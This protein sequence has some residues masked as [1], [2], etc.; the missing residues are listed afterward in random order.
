MSQKRPKFRIMDLI[1]ATLILAVIMAAVVRLSTG[2]FAGVSLGIV[3]AAITISRMRGYW[4]RLFTWS[5]CI[6]PITAIICLYTAWLAAWIHVGH[7]PRNTFDDPK[8]LGLWVEI[9][10]KLTYLHLLNHKEALKY[11]SILVLL[12]ICY[13]FIDRKSRG[14]ELAIL[15]FAPAVLWLMFFLLLGWD[16]G[17][18]LEWYMD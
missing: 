9:P 17:G 16:P 14:I 10:Y 15:L 13:W 2:R 7:R 18:V 8:Y 4:I 1:E 3:L 5:S 11:C 12:N 6:Y